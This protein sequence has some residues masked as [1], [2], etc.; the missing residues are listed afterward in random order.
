VRRP[1]VPL[2]LATAALVLAP[3]PARSGAAAAVSLPHDPAVGIGEQHAEIFSDPHFARL[4][5]RRLR[6]VIGWDALQTS[7]QRAEADA[8][9][10]QA[11]ATGAKVLVAFNVSRTPARKHILPSVAQYRR[12]FL[13]FKRRYPFVREYATWNEANHGSQPTFRRPRRVAR[14]YDV[15]RNACPNCTILAADLLD[16]STLPGYVR[17]VHRRARREPR[18]WG[19]HNYIDAN[20]FRAS[21]TRGLLR[22][23]PGRVW[24]TETG[25]I[26]W[27]KHGPHTIPLAEGPRHAARALRWLFGLARAH[28]RVTRVYLYHWSYPRPRTTWDSALIDNRGRPRPAYRTLRAILRAAAARRARARQ[29]I[30]RAAAAGRAHAR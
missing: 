15:M 5:L 22:S 27:R 6:Y 10:G 3:A 11:Q 18:I 9:M 20:R 17:T 14:Y 8:W 7:W 13:A 12:A 29:P 25:G 19:L 2:A 24:F 1:L 16:S 30:L 28:R 26:V 4:G 23:V 21:G